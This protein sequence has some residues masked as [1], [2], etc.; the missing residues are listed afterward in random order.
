[1]KYLSSGIY[2]QQVK[3]SAEESVC[4]HCH[5]LVA[6]VYFGGVATEIVP[7]GIE[8][9]IMAQVSVICLKISLS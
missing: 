8:N 4:L 3:H 5:L 2:L 1:M 9:V 7:S 6:P